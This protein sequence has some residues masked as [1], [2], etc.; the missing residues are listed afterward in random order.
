VLDCAS[1]SLNQGIRET[2]VRE[3]LKRADSAPDEWAKF[4]EGL[5][6]WNIGAC[7]L[8]LNFDQDKKQKEST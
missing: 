4:E 7:Y 1:A 6:C 2:K 5:C 8:D 3:I